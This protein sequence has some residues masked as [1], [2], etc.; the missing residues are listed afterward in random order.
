MMVIKYIYVLVAKVRKN[1]L[2]DIYNQIKY[3]LPKNEFLLI[4]NAF[5]F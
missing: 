5:I 4:E 1:K 3:E 2:H